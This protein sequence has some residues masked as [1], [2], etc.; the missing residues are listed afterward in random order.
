MPGIG[1][2]DFQDQISDQKKTVSFAE[3]TSD[4]MRDLY[5]SAS[6]STCYV[7]T[8]FSVGGKVRVFSLW[9]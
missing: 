7:R 6:Q 1:E 8:S 5:F 2:Y 9:D 4:L 3:E